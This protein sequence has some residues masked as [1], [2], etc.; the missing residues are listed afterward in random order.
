MKIKLINIFLIINIL[1]FN[2]YQNAKEVLIYADNISYDE[3]ENLIA[4]GN[5]KIISENRIIQSNL[6]IYNKIKEIY[7]LPIDFN[8]KDEGGNF[9]YGSSGYFSND[10]EEAEIMDSKILLND[11]SRIV[12]NKTKRKGSIDIVSKGSYSSCTSRIN[13]KNFE[14]PIWQLDGEKIIHDSENLLLYQKHSKMR[15]FNIPVLYL[16]YLVTP[17]PLRK[18]RKSGFLNPSLSFNFIN[19]ETPQSIKL[20]Y[21][22]NIDIDKELT[23]TPIINYGGGTDSKQRML[24]DYN[25]I[26]SGGNFNFDIST[27]TTINENN[28]S[29]WFS[30]A[31]LILDY[32]KNINETYNIKANSVLQ[33]TQTYLRSSD[34]NNLY[35][36]NTSLS[37][38]I[39]LNGYGVLNNNDRLYVNTTTYQV[40]QANEDNRTTPTSLPYIN[41]N[42]GFKKFKKI[43]YENSYQYY[44]IF[45]ENK[46]N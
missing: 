18:K 12:G 25:Q 22:F 23:F 46:H 2:G 33:T 38:S 14:C 1:F 10:L 19:T 45:R 16:P 34:P 27:D 17:S 9:Y 37:S 35:S 3:K 6:I 20:P 28:S 41:Y 24:F 11:G 7:I 36:S 8:F 42:G 31:S 4:K 29:K 26:I 40:V 32:E 21:Y 30:D 39:K 13:I 44:N 15:I 5:V 43:D